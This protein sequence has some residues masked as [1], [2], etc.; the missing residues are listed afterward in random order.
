ML[1]WDDL[2][3]LLALAEAG[4]LSGAARKLAVEH[5]TVA[6]R[7]AALEQRVAARLVDRRGGRYTLTAAG[8]TVTEHARRMREEALAIE[9][10]GLVEGGGPVTEVTATMPPPIAGEL[11]V[12]RL[13]ALEQ[14]KPWLRL[15]IVSTSQTLSLTRREADVALRL[16]RPDAPPVIA[17]RVGQLD[18]G[19]FAAAGYLPR[20]EPDFGFIG[21][22]DDFAQATQ[23]VWLDRIA[24][25]RRTVFR[26]NDLSL[27][28]AA[29]KAGMGIAALP[30][31]LGEARGLTAVRP[32]LG[33]SR[34]I[35]ISYHRDSKSS[36]AVIAAVEF[37]IQCLPRQ[38]LEA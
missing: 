22:E 12:P 13:P 1:D 38:S 20:A 24:G 4:S 29:A 27:Q 5:A 35:W 30:V 7:I 23:Q 34:E 37:L 14:A 10:I 11:V 15:K 3:H 28:C 21:L 2:R 31:F 8:E 17:R 6:R 18:Y 16:S 36:P 26:S 9:R 33:V 25:S 32:D 19:M